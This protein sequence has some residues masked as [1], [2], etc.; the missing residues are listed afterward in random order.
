MGVFE[1]CPS[2]QV[3]SVNGRTR[4]PFIP[5][6]LRLKEDSR[7]KERQ[8]LLCFTYILYYRNIVWEGGRR[9]LPEFYKS[10][11]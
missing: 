5:T 11:I 2:K 9:W 10:L 3:I 7:N 1:L 8:S 6:K 4:D